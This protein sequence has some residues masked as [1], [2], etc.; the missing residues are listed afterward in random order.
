MVCYLLNEIMSSVEFLSLVCYLLDN[1]LMLLGIVSL[2]MWSYSLH[3]FVLSVVFLF[4]QIYLIQ[5]ELKLSGFFCV[6][7]HG[8]LFIR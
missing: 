4:L 6:S 7:G 5:D 8:K 2:F 1:D 3:E